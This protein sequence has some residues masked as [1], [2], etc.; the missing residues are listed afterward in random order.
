M[1][2]Q[3]ILI[4]DDSEMN[5][6]LLK[7]F[8]EEDYDFL[9]AKDGLEAVNVLST[10]SNEISLVL[11]DINM[12]V[13]DGFEVLEAMREH[14]W[15]DDIPVIIISAESGISFAKRG[16][17]L[18]A[19]DYIN[20]PFDANIVQKRVF[21]T[22]KLYE[23]QKKL[24]GLV[25]EQIY[26][27]QRDNSMLVAILSHIVEFRNEESGA[28]VQ[29]IRTLT[30]LFINGLQKISDYKF[31]H[32]EASRICMA[33]SLH[34]I[35]KI[36][37]PDGILNKPGRLTPE[38]FAIMKTHSAAG[39]EM[40]DKLPMYKD[41]PLVKTAYRICRWHH[42][43]FDGRGYPD[44]LIG[45]EIP[46]EAQIVSLADVYD[47][48]TSPR[49]YKPAYSHEEAVRMINNGE[50]GSFNPLLLQVLS[51]ITKE[52]FDEMNE[53]AENPD[54]YADVKKI[55]EEVMNDSELK[56]PER[57]L[58]LLEFE[59][60]RSAFLASLN[61]DIHFEIIFKP[62]ILNLS[63]TGAEMLAVSPTTLNPQEDA[64]ILAAFGKETVDKIF[65]LCKSF[66]AKNTDASFTC[67]MVIGGNARKTEVKMRSVWYNGKS[68][69]GVIGNIK[70]I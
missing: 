54:N 56:A 52:Q 62:T 57:T 4:A 61:S 7:D 60:S 64:K 51:T 65:E 67:E 25:E 28:H 53:K 32:E 63:E 69:T 66:T 16:Y 11:L 68:L 12:P 41:E 30:E 39:A 14:K 38:E 37:I 22:I 34:D 46:I 13:M 23:K 20:R 29:H 42:E 45:D 6:E 10:R 27:K 18:G 33:S 48:L 43:R 1:K 24:F 9:E 58:E 50:C 70:I 3:I 26:E 40:L 35:G 47:A 31:T 19:T 15:I 2:K 49:V 8:L 44:R 17:N 36:T 59:K 21:N 5:R 55:T